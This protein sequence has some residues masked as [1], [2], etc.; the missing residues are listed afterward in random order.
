MVTLQMQAKPSSV[1]VKPNP[2]VVLALIDIEFICN[3]SEVEMQIN[4]LQQ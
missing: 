2:S 3:L 1:P 4:K